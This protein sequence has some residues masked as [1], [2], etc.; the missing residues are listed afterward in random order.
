MLEALDELAPQAEKRVCVRHLYQNV[1]QRWSGK[2][3]KDAIWAAARAC[4]EVDFKVA[5]EEIKGLSEECHKYLI[6]SDPSTWSRHAFGHHTKSDMLLNNICE[7]FNAYILPAREKPVLSM[8]EW[9]R[10]TLMKRFVTK[11]Q[12]MLDY[13]GKFTPKATKLIALSKDEATRYCVPY[14]GGGETFEVDHFGHTYIVN[15][16]ARSCGCRKWDLTGIP[17]PHAI[18]CI[19]KDRRNIED[20]VDNCYTKD[21]YLAAYS[22]II[23][24]MPGEDNWEKAAQ[25]PPLP[26]RYVVQPG[27]PRKKRR[28]EAGEKATKKIR[29]G[30]TR[31]CTNCGQQGHYK[32]KCKNGRKAASP[33]REQNKGGRPKN[34][35]TV[36][37]G[38]KPRKYKK[39]VCTELILSLF[40]FV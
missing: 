8:F 22:H 11:R 23:K 15:L 21:K 9:I 13:V 40:F 18:C 25:I 19:L 5:M 39:R 34:P 10:R 3:I 20:Y 35:T 37:F 27:R 7:S 32:N 16:D 12:G 31:S 38:S 24:A 30:G 17:C 26:P 14:W 33:A 1:K 4:N 29:I 36:S 6:D 28:R 2:A